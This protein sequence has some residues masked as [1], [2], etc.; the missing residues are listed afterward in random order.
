MNGI[1]FG[2]IVFL[3]CMI[4]LNL[5]PYNNPTGAIFAI[6]G[7]MGLAHSFH[8]LYTERVSELFAE[9]LQDVVD[10]M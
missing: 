1:Q 8:C 4:I 5:I 9:L 6:I 7:G 10:S 2:I 3:L